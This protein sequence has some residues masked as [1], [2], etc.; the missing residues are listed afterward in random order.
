[1][2]LD[3]HA[4]LY[5]DRFD[6]DRAQVIERTREAGFVSVINVGTDVRSSQLAIDLAVA[7]PGFCYAAVGLH[8]NET[9]KTQH[10]LEDTL[11]ELERLA[12]THPQ[13]VCAWGEIGL[14]Y[15]WDSCTPQEQARSFRLQLAIAARRNL[16]VII[17]CR[18]AMEDTLAIVAE[19][20]NEVRGVFHCFGGN[21]EQ[22]LRAVDLGWWVSFAG[23]LTFPKATE[24]REAASVVPVERLLLETDSPFLSPHPLRG[25]RCEP[26]FSLHT[27]RV[28]AELRGLEPTALGRT[29]TENARELFRLAVGA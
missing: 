27:L 26:A 22:A 8:P 4:H 5:F 11:S 6:E 13:Q 23:N 25:Q 3:S 12:D 19:F 15:Y 10:P 14:D 28:L 20:R 16:P 9:T 18:D 24:L 21:A 2:Y 29:T 1:M 7:H 17:H